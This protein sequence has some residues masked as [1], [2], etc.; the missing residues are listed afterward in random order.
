MIASNDNA[1]VKNVREL[2]SKHKA[3]V[4]Q[5]LFVVEGVKMCMEAPLERISRVFVSESFYRD[6]DNR[7][8]LEEKS[9]HFIDGDKL[10][11]VKDSVFEG[12]CDTKTPQGIL[13][14]VAMKETSFDELFESDKAPFIMILESIQDPGNLGTIIRTAEGAGVTGI[15]INDTTVDLYNPKTIR[16]TMG[17]LYR[18]KIYESKNLKETVAELKKRGIKTYAAHLKGKEFYYEKSYKEPVAFMIGNEGN[19]LTDEL[20]DMADTYIK[21][22]M[23]GSVESLNA[24]I[25]A[26][27]LM[28]ETLRQ[29][30]G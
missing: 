29:R 28:Y 24:G 4:T 13:T 30:R 26:S 1:K 12:M 19:G 7:K 23:E 9:L 6:A 18:M 8:A 11:V 10:F 15:V 27:V 21:I 2:N 20:S 17:S 3:R 16:S 5:S 25:A 22:P 14:V